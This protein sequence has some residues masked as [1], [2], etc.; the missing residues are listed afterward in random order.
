MIGQYTVEE[1]QKIVLDACSKL[2]GNINERYFIVKDSN[3]FSVKEEILNEI[4]SNGLN[5]MKYV[6]M[7]AY[8]MQS[9][10]DVF[11]SLA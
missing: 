2:Y 8:I 5:L 1:I 11:I 6:D 4:K 9:G 3:A 10:K 7:S